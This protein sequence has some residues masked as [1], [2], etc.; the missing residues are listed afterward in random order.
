MA[1]IRIENV[2]VRF[3]RQTFAARP[4]AGLVRRG[5]AG[6]EDRAYVE[7]VVANAEGVAHTGGAITALDDVTL[8]IADGET[9][10]V[11]GPSGCGKS[12]LLRV[13]AGLEPPNSGR[14]L[15]DGRDM[16]GVPPGQRG[17][18]MVFQSYAL[19]PHM[20]GQGNLG[21]FFKIHRRPSEEMMERIRITSEIMGLGFDELLPRRP[22]TLSGGQQQRVAIGRCIVRDPTLFL[23]DEPL[24]N[25][26]ARLRAQTRVEIK[27]LL[28]RFAITSVYVTHDQTEATAL[29]DRIVVMSEG[30]VVQVGTF[31]ELW[32]NPVNTFVA[33][34]VGMPPMN[35]IEGCHL[36]G[37]R[38]LGPAGA[39]T[40]PSLTRG[41]PEGQSLTCGYRSTEAQFLPA[42]PS[43]E[44]E[45]LVLS[46]IVRS[47]QPDLTRQEQT[48]YLEVGDR[49]L[50]VTVP[51]NVAL[52]V[53]ET[54]SA[55][56]PPQSL[57]LF[58]GDTGLR[59][60][61]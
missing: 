1:E 28:R 2:T 61:P 46:G 55:L 4:S 39:V 50:S 58:D 53:G 44:T 47:I 24:S 22:R 23:F 36:S 38:L 6:Y 35:L 5:Y 34:F 54:A 8:H 32:D 9:V 3:A 52:T 59:I 40:C 42:A 26:D 27:R 51:A 48:L 45:G 29:G 30:R 57:Y 25:L 33:G 14:V 12:T 18:G 20:E 21:F 13:I 37:G 49:L 60:L 7:R 19:Y 16:A 10:T 56:I 41:L 17:I 31:R 43:P 15:Y 11:I